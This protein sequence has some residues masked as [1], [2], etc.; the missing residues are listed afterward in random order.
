MLPTH[1]DW[2][3]VFIPSVV[4]YNVPNG[5][6]LRVRDYHLTQSNLF[7]FFFFNFI[8][9]TGMCV[10]MCI[11]LYSAMQCNIQFRTWISI[12]NQSFHVVPIKLCK[13]LCKVET[14]FDHF[15]TDDNMCACFPRVTSRKNAQS[16]LYDPQVSCKKI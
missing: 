12:Y 10:C 13:V 1:N 4:S 14:R 7:R 6:F 16:I 9:F 8:A 2:V 5:L 11:I 3:A 15:R